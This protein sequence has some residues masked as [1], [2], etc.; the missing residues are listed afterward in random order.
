[1]LECHLLPD[2]GLVSGVARLGGRRRTDRRGGT[3]LSVDLAVEHRAQAQVRLRSGREAHLGSRVPATVLQARHGDLRALHGGEPDGHVDDAVLLAADDGVTA[4]D[5]DRLVL[6]L[7]RDRGDRATT[8]LVDVDHVR[9]GGFIECQVCRT[10]VLGGRVECDDDEA[11]ALHRDDGSDAVEELGDGLAIGACHAVIQ[12]RNRASSCGTGGAWRHHRLGV[13]G[14]PSH[15]GRRPR[16]RRYD[17][18]RRRLSRVSTPVEPSLATGWVRMP[19]RPS[20]RLLARK[21][22]RDVHGFLPWRPAVAV[23]RFYRRRD[24]QDQ[25]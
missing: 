4:E 14:R 9:L 5:D 12:G 6:R 19:L 13:S 15:P 24:P 21:R 7:D 2:R 20:S 8:E 23:A 11:V 3:R 16:R 22:P 17:Q 18:H 25:Q 10:G 1:M